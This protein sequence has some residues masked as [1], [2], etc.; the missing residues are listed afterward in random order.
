MKWL[1]ENFFW[2][3]IILGVLVLTIVTS[4]PTIMDMGDGSFFK[5]I[6][7]LPVALVGGVLIFKA[8]ALLLENTDKVWK[9]AIILVVMAACIIGF[10]ALVKNL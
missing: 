9:G 6:I 7:L 4:L 3:L 1:K 8:F 5:G 10:V 2:I